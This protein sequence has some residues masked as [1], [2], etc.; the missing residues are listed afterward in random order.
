M[1]L[2]SDFVYKLDNR[3]AVTDVP[4]LCKVGPEQCLHDGILTTMLIGQQ[5]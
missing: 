4:T 3:L 1:P 5:E 2:H